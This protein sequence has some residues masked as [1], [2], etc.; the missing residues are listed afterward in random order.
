MRRVL[1]QRLERLQKVDSGRSLQGGQIGIEKESLRVT[2]DGLIAQSEHPRA[3]GSALTHPYVTTDYS[4]ALLE[5]RT[6]PLVGLAKT[7]DSLRE[8]HQIVDAALGD[9]LLWPASMPCRLGGDASIPIARYG[10]SNIGMMKHIYRRG[11]EHRYGRT[12]QSIAGVH[13]NY[14]LPQTVWPVF[15]EWSDDLILQQ[16]L[17]SS[18]YFGLVRNFQRLAWIVAYLFG[19]SPAVDESFLEGGCKRL[20]RGTDGTCIGPTATSLRMSDMGYHNKTQEQLDIPY[21]GIEAYVTALAAATNTSYPGYER[22][23]TKVAGEYRQLNSNILQVE[24]EYYSCVR[25]KQPIQSGERSTSALRR[26]GVEYVEVRV[27]D[28]DP[29]APLGVNE[30]ELRF[31]EALMI[32]CALDESPPISAQERREMD[33]NQDLVTLRGRDARVMLSRRG[34]TILL[35]EW[36]GQILEDMQPI[37]ELL[38]QQRAS[39]DYADTLAAQTETV[40]D[41][42][43]TPAAR[44]L[45]EMANKRESFVDFGLRKAREHADYFRGLNLSAERE[46][47]FVAAAETSLREQAEIEKSDTVGFDEYLE[48]YFSEH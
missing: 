13:F 28:V 37:C 18:T 20:K 4:E 43:R 5:L 39:P 32:Y 45:V 8:I 23:G 12:M 35:K 42:E 29:F 16:D 36:A 44:M 2:P 21:D 48:H 10:T 9:E 46:R 40:R 41:A 6:P 17:M 24:N 22:I 27:V 47:H 25:P 38:D 33:E 19:A 3:L 1:E 15:A 11:L 26:R 30:Q 7:L 14:S 34:Q 31:L